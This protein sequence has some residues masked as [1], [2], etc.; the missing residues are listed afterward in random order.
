MTALRLVGFTDLTAPSWTPGARLRAEQPAARQPLLRPCLRRGGAGERRRRD[1]RGRRSR[2]RAHRL[3]ACQRDGSVLRPVGWPGADF[4]GPVLAPGTAFD[5]RELLVD[6]VRAFEFDHWL[7]PCPEVEP[8]VETR[9][10][11]PYVE[12]SGGL[13]GYLSRASKSGRDNIGQARRRTARAER[14]LGAGDVLC[15]VLGRR[16]TRLAGGSQ[17]RAVRRHGSA[18]PLRRPRTA[19][20]CSR[21]CWT[22]TSPAARGSCRPCTS[23]TRSWRRTSASGPG[24]CCT[25]G[26]RSTTRRSRASRPAGSCCGS[27]R[28]SRPSSASSGSTSAEATTSTSAGPAPVRSRWPPA[29]SR[30]ARVGASGTR[31]AARPSRRRRPRRWRR[32]CAEP[33]T[34]GGAGQVEA[35]QR[36]RRAQTMA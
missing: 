16:G 4:Q 11:S 18:R 15:A 35:G 8:W 34:R 28:W 25:G 7:L 14:E 22:P 32:C 12:V 9:A 23:G 31:R 20:R 24:A 17:A 6:G 3:L 27:W 30:A 2:V 29:R 10:A 33:C 5:P 36:T 13:D 19:A 26:S 1:G 21:C